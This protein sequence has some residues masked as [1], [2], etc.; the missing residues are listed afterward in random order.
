MGAHESTPDAPNVCNCC[1]GDQVT[2]VAFFVHGLGHNGEKHGRA[3][4]AGAQLA[5]WHLHYVAANLGFTRW[6]TFA[7][8][9]GGI[10][11]GGYRVAKEV[12]EVVTATKALEIAFVGASLGGLFCRYAAR[13]LWPDAADSELPLPARPLALVTLATPHLGV[14]GLVG[15]GQKWLSLGRAVSAT[16]A[17]LMWDTS[18]LHDLSSGPSLQALGRFGTRCA[19]A[20]TIDDGIVAYPSAAITPRLAVPVSGGALQ[21]LGKVHIIDGAAAAEAW[22]GPPG[23]GFA[24]AEGEASAVPVST[25]EAALALLQAGSWEIVD[26][27]AT[28]K[29]VATLYPVTR[30]GAPNV[31]TA[32]IATDIWRRLAGGGHCSE[33]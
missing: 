19:Y 20:P 12:R 29:D 28:H 11:A 9:L 23:E 10:E 1:N 7:N 18:A 25:R 5:G 32:A 15:T 6:G 17:D 16:V 31:V 33:R 24:A 30:A 14:R 8:T 3:L 2:R 21:A 26:V 27:D 13:L 4:A 22:C